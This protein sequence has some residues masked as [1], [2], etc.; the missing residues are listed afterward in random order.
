[1]GLVLSFVHDESSIY[2]VGLRWGSKKMMVI[3]VLILAGGEDKKLQR[4]S[5]L[6]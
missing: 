1:M 4:V 5:S 6:E 3:S 2:H